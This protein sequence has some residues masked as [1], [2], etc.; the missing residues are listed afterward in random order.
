MALTTL[1]NVSFFFATDQGTKCAGALQAFSACL[2][3]KLKFK[4]N[5]V[6]TC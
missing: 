2:I 1:V 6:K 5:P 3:K 4:P